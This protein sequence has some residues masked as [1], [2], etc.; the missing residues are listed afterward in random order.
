VTRVPDQDLQLLEA[1]LDDELSADEVE[2]LR[3]RLIDEPELAGALAEVREGREARQKVFAAMEPGELA[4]SDSVAGMQRA[5]RGRMRWG[6]R[7]RESLRYVAAAAC[8]T[9][10]VWIGQRASQPQMQGPQQANYDSNNS[11]GS[12][13]VG[14]P[15]VQ[16]HGDVVQVSWPVQQVAA[17]GGSQQIAGASMLGGGGNSL[18]SRYTLRPTLPAV[19]PRMVVLTDINGTIIAAQQFD[20]VAEAREFVEDLRRSA[21]ASGHMLLPITPAQAPGFVP[22]PVTTNNNQAVP[23]M[24]GKF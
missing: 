22:A 8:V 16:D 6:G 3:D 11:G 1:Y 12:V 21:E 10:G 20:T 15:M 9:V 19:T 14:R 7:V 4:V 2:A 13:A 5:I 18:Q 17:N 23:V 24:A